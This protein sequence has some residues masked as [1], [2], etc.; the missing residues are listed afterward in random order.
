MRTDGLNWYL[1]GIPSQISRIHFLLNCTWLS[2][3]DQILGHKTNLHKFKNIEIILSI[4]SDHNAEIRYQL[5][6]KTV[7][8]TNK[9]RLSNTLLTNEKI[10][11]ATKK[12][13]KNTH[14]QMIAKTQW[15]KTTIGWFCSVAQSCL[16][17]CD[18]MDCS[19]PG[20]P[21]LHCLLELAQT[22][23]HWVSDAIQS[24]HPLSSAF[25]IRVFSNESALCIRLPKY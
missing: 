5:Q 17:L 8:N 6:G 22:H 25:S 4:F 12:K 1:H 21:V 15:P 2:R 11:K 13:I 10:T 16:T 20:F 9:W 3:I 7:K 24:S 18:P 14:K 19:L 23:V